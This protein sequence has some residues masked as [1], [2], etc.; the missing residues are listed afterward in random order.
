MKTD[1]QKLLDLAESVRHALIDWMH[2]RNP[3]LLDSSKLRD[4]YIESDGILE[5]FILEDEVENNP[6]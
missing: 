2:T 1:K 3:E 6:S 5:D 4:L